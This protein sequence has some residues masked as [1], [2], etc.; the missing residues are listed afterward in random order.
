MET[1]IFRAISKETNTPVIGDL[2]TQYRSICVIKDDNL[3]EHEVK[4]QTLSIH[5]PGMVDKNLKDIFASLN[6]DGIGGDRLHIEDCEGNVYVAYYNTARY[7]MAIVAV[8]FEEGEDW[9][10]GTFAEYGSEFFEAIGIHIK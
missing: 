5:L 9:E 3:I 1:P 4:E 10:H 7:E 2:I 8:E 6:K